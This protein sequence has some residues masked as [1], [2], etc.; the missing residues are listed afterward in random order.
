MLESPAQATY[1]VVLVWEKQLQG[2][3]RQ[4]VEIESTEQTD[5]GQ[6]QEGRARQRA[7][8]TEGAESLGIRSFLLRS[9][10]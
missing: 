5:T 8:G 2:K 10:F 7:W 9:I 6:A 4:S 3:P 1:V